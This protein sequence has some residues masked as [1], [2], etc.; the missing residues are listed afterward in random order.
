MKGIRGISFFIYLMLLASRTVAQVNVSTEDIER[1]RHFSENIFGVGLH[2]SL[3]TGFGLS[4]RQRFAGTA[5]AYQIN[6]GIIKVNSFLYYDIGGELQFDL[7]GSDF[8]RI[9]VIGGIGYYYSGENGKN[10]LKT[11]LR[12]GIGLG[13]EYAFTRQIGI[14]LGLLISGFFPNGDILPLPQI[15][16]H[17]FFK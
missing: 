8:D 2:G 3:V 16:I 6:G 9:Y 7:S 13:Y 17:Y 11:P 5:I 14:S 1:P 10:D 4:F 12:I 15:G